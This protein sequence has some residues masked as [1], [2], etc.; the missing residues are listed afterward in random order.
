MF[1]EWD[2]QKEKINIAKHGISFTSAEYVFGDDNRIEWYDTKHSTPDEDRYITIGF[3]DDVMLIVSV[4]YTP[5]G[6][7]DEIIRLISARKATRSEKEAYLN[8]NNTY[9]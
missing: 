6:N 5:R 2:E 8:A 1:F 7:N 4:V 3:S 9:C